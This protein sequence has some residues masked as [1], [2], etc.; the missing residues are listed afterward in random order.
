MQARIRLF[1][2]DGREVPPHAKASIEPLVGNLISRPAMS[3]LTG[4]GSLHMW[5]VTER[6]AELAKLTE[7]RFVK[8]Y[9]VEYL[10]FEG[11]EEIGRR[12]E[13]QRWLVQIL[14]PVEDTWNR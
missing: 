13:P 5:L 4:A 3:G 1:F 2:K 8:T 12:V 11:Q 14:G 10:M 6:G 9:G 7:V